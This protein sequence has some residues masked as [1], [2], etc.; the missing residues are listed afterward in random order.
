MGNH[1]EGGITSLWYYSFKW[2]IT[3]YSAGLAQPLY[4]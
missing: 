2:A 1:L 4:P 3:L